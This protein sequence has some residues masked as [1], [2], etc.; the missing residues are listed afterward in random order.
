MY[1]LFLIFWKRKL[2]LFFCFMFFR[3]WKLDRNLI[4][5]SMSTRAARGASV[6]GYRRR[7]AI[8]DLDLNTA[9]PSDSRDQE[10]TSTQVVPNEI[11]TGQLGRSVPA[12]IDVEAI[13]DDVIESSPRAFAEVWLF[14]F[15]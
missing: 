4:V 10:G 6:R 13:D 12:M 5:F 11:E 2:I 14:N 7:K 15:I 3:L 1:L 8:L 9:P